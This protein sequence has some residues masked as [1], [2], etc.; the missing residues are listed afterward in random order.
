MHISVDTLDYVAYY[1]AILKPIRPVHLEIQTHRANPVGVLRSSFRQGDKIQ[2]NNHGRITGLALDQ[3]KLIQA[4]FRGDVVPKDSPQA[5]QT[6]NSREYGASHALLQM[7]KELEL[8]RAL[9]SR[10]EP[11]VQD[12]LAMIVGRIIYAGS[13]LALSN[14]WKNTA[15]WELCGVEGPIDVEEHCYLP[16]DRLLE[17]QKAIQRTLASKHLQNG[18]MVL[19][20]ITST[21]FEGAYL[22]SDIVLF[23]YNR[24][25]KKG[26]EQVVLGLLCNAEGCPVGVEVFAGNTQDASTV[27]TKIQELRRDYRLKQITFVGDRGMVTQSNAEELKQVEGLHTISALTHRQIVELVERKVIEA[28]LFD[29]QRIAEVID[30]AKPKQRY[31]LCRNP[32]SGARETATRQRLLDRTREALEKIVGRKK[33]GSTEKLSAQVGKILA[34]YKM[35][36][37]V[38]W[39]IEA[40][41]L[42]WQFKEAHIKQEKLFD[43]CYIV[44]ATVP[45]AQM[46]QDEIVA[47]YKNLSVVE[48]AFRN[49]KTVSLE[50]RPVYHK[51]DDRIRSHV[52]LCVLA[53]YLQWHMQQRLQPLFEAN[54]EGKNRQWTM[55]NVIERLRAIRKQRVKVAEVE[56]D[57]V[58]QADQEQ[59]K[60]LDLM[61]VKL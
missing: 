30:P 41:R 44:S 37:F 48:Q 7:A 8:D 15:L 58:T 21:Y 19:Y 51:K 53:F 10:H 23:G 46:N 36:K 9:Y 18:H 55:E 4:A 49:L 47:T 42:K 24:D 22:E 28:E 5:F 11:W 20:D 16:M 17:R 32:L 61:K 50:I 1:V 39:Q 56:F 14:Q 60:I 40:G 29:E 6:L 54:G 38:Q 12:C 35:G 13:K 43:G 45:K 33:K 25:G 34:H 31:C 57:Q 2:H 59:Q 26:H 52:F 27:V 3:L